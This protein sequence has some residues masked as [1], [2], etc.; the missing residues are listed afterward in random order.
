M[1][2]RSLPN[3]QDHNRTSFTHVDIFSLTSY[4]DHICVRV[5][6]R[7]E[8][9]HHQVLNTGSLPTDFWHDIDGLVVCRADRWLSDHEPHCIATLHESSRL[10][11][12]PMERGRPRCR[13][14]G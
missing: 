6:L 12:E 5:H 2:T 3:A 7:V 4:T 13:S 8:C 14:S 11:L 1:V 10:L 9:V